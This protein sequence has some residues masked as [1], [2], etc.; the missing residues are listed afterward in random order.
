VCRVCVAARHKQR[1]KRRKYVWSQ[2]SYL[3]AQGAQVEGCAELHLESVAIDAA[4]TLMPIRSRPAA[5]EVAE[6]GE[7]RNLCGGAPAR[8]IVCAVQH[9]GSHASLV[10]C[11]MGSDAG[12][13]LLVHV[14]F[15]AGPPSLPLQD[16]FAA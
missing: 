9:C 12:W 2:P 7:S 8:P 16:R 1:C 15:A 10:C 14:R 13:T 6:G 11:S 5:I 3:R 4:S